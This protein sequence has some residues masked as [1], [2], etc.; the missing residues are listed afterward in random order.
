M[1]MTGCDRY[2]P[3]KVTVLV[4]M[5]TVWEN[6]TH[7]I[8]MW[9]PSCQCLTYT[10]RGHLH[11]TEETQGTLVVHGFNFTSGFYTVT[12]PKAIHPYLAY[13]IEGRGFWTNK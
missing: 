8:P 5:G 9:N 4:G 11:E 6:L 3:P 13:Y 12:I 7:S 10:S 1:Q 2:Y